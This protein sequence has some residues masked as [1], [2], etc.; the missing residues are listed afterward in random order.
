MGNWAGDADEAAD[1]RDDKRE[2]TA[3]LTTQSQEAKIQQSKAQY[4]LNKEAAVGS[5]IVC[6]SCGKKFFK[7]LYNKLFCS[8]QTSSSQSN[9]KDLYWN[10]TEPKRRRRGND[11]LKAKYERR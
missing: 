4:Q 2:L 3:L 9:C 7:A 1:I 8:N 11:F 5:T 6:P 10:S